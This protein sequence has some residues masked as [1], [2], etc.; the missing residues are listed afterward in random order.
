MKDIKEELETACK[1]RDEEIKQLKR[2]INSKDQEVNYLKAFRLEQKAEIK[3]LREA[4]EDMIDMYSYRLDDLNI[5][6]KRGECDLIYRVDFILKE[7][8]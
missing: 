1:L 7:I 3:K 8:E 6:L 4:L 5:K 2:Y